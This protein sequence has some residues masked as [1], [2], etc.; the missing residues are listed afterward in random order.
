VCDCDRIASR[1]DG[2]PNFQVRP[3]PEP[4]NR[5]PH[6]PALP[7]VPIPDPIRPQPH[8]LPVINRRT[9]MTLYDHIQELR[10]ELRN[11]VYRDE[12]VQIERELAQAEAEQQARDDA[13][14]ADL[15]GP[16]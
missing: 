7:V 14:F 5:L 10:A 13:M 9:I 1:T 6:P 4:E 16:D 15:F 3:S 11:A 8:D 12:R 2:S